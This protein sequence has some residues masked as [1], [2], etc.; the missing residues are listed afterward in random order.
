MIWLQ[1]TDILPN[2]KLCLLLS[3]TFKQITI[4]QLTGILLECYTTGQ[5]KILKEIHGQMNL[6]LDFE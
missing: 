2:I 3:P 6:G 1:K 5:H 4:H